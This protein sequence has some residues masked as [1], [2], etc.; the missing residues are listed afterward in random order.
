MKD[1]I[2]I[3]KRNFLSPIVIAIFVLS[4]I[5]LILG[6]FRDA[7]FISSV[8]MI[9]TILGI[10]QE[11][12]ARNKLR[13]LEL[14][15]LPHA[16]RL[17]SDGSFENILFNELRAGNKVGLEI[18]EEVPADGIII[19]SSGLEVNESIL[20]GESNPIKKN[21]SAKVLAV[22]AVVAG[23]GLMLVKA[24]GDKTMAGK[25]S[26]SLKR[27]EPETTPI[28]R[29][30]ARAITYLTYG[31]LGL[32]VLI[33]VV[34]FLSGQDAVKIFK[35]IA[36]GAITVVPEGLLFASTILLAYGSIRLAQVK[37]LPQKLSAIEAM[38]LLE[39]LCVDKTGTLTS[40]EVKF[41]GVES[42]DKTNK[43]PVKE[44]MAI[45]AKE[46]SGGSKTGVAIANGLTLPK[47]YE[48]VENLAFS[49]ARK[50]SG[51]RVKLNKKLYSVIMGAPEYLLKYTELDDYQS[52]RLKDLT[53]NGNRVLMAVMFD[54][55]QMPLASLKQAKVQS[56]GLAVL[57]NELRDGVKKTV[58]YL[59]TN[60]VEIKVISGDN[61]ETVQYI[62][63]QAGI[64]NADKA[65][66]GAEL[67]ELSAEDWDSVVSSTTVFARILPEQKQLLIETFSRLGKFS[68][69]VG[70][71]INDALAI[72]KAD[73]GV[74][75]YAGAAAT[76]RVADVVLLDNSFNSLPVGM[77]L[78]NRIMQA[79]EL[80]ATLFFHKISYMVVLLLSTLV[81][82]IPYPF[83]P[84]HITFMN[85]F[86]VS[87]PTLMWTIFTPLPA[88]RL[89]PKYFWKDTLLA[90]APIAAMTG[91][92]V[93][94]SYIFLDL[95][96]PGDASGVATTTVIIATFFGI[97]L[98]F[99]VSKMFNIRNNRSAKLARLL[100]IL[101]VIFVLSISFGFGFSRDFFDFT[102][103]AWRN[104]LPLLML[105]VCVSIFQWKIA[106]MAGD[107]ISRR[108]GSQKN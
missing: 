70:D 48:I 7:W 66:T 76:R 93:T 82:G 27:Y 25:M 44:L 1:F 62:T 33:L 24:V 98:V 92:I 4:V 46:T 107:R 32:A 20:T 54:D 9:N 95:I 13:K 29:S 37:V 71:G 108:H 86:L 16:R 14:M 10:I 102:T 49:S 6:E 19:E 65:L 15:N 94:L 23:S 64:K 38:A 67:E 40:D 85:M 60:E 57:S 69:M 18:G 105:I 88:H 47:E 61:L 26:S 2:V 28:Q 104:S 106:A 84:R 89:S 79:I 74:A 91:L 5:L 51:V 30:I 34:Y 8:I 103:P 41:N 39:I 63:K 96:H 99:L 58:R 45:I 55:N 97:Y 80:I 101:A 72:K 43:L 73:F 36:A 31:A 11:T 75:M 22:S 81:L 90:V 35:T 56:I 52:R 53:S 87:M 77:R 42:F 3:L 59:Q 78:G 21:K 17:K 50:Y 100:Y 12:R 83:E 68:G